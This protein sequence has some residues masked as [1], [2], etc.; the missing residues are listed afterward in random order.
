MSYLLECTLW[1]YGENMA[2]KA[3]EKELQDLGNDPPANC[4]AEPADDD[5]FNWQATS[6]G[7]GGRA[8]PIEVP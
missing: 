3:I 1:E 5:L 8:L 7:S 6:M 2:L 4:S